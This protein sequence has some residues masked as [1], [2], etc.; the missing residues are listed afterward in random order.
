M[1][2]LG[3]CHGNSFSLFTQQK[4]FLTSPEKIRELLDGG[5]SSKES[6]N[7]SEQTDVDVLRRSS[8]APSDATNKDSFFSRVETYSCLKWAGKPRTL[9]PL[10]CARYG[11][12]NVSCDMLK[13]CSCQAFLCASLQPTVDLEKYNSRVEELTRQLQTQHERFCPWPDCPSPERL[14]LVSACEPST[15][16]TSFLERY[17]SAITLAQQL[18]A[19]K[20]EQLKSLSLTEDVISA[21]LQLIDKELKEKNRAPCSA[22]LDVQVAASI[23]SVFGWSASLVHQSAKLPLLSCSYCMRKVGLWNFH[24]MEWM[25]GDGEASANSESPSTQAAVPAP[26]EVPGDISSAASPSCRMKL[27]SQDTTRPDL[28]ETA[29]LSLLTRGKRP[30][31]RSR[32]LGDD[33]GAMQQSSKRLCLSS[34]D[35]TDCPLQKEAFNPISQHRDWCPWITEEKESLDSNAATVLEGE[36]PAHQRGWKAVLDLLVPVTS[37]LGGSQVQGPRDKSKKVFAIFHQWQ[38]SSESK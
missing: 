15:L 33:P 24:Q 35:N 21:L 2:A 5:V 23:V 27:R 26:A 8:Q 18:P 3:D 11:W 25:A 22:P 38:V 31:T 9:S 14:W 29:S 10:M 17:E 20:P 36:S 7:V 6:R 1:A 32:G 19:M 28:G 4:S 13:C 37:D 12:T 16:L 30:A 34:F